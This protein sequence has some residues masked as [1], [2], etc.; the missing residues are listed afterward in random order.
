MTSICLLSAVHECCAAT[1]METALHD[2]KPSDQESSLPVAQIY[3]TNLGG[4]V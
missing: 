3:S 2:R 4:S 1:N